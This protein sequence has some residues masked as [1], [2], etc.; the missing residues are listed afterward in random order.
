MTTIPGLY[1]I[2]WDDIKHAA[3]AVGFIG[4]PFYCIRNKCCNWLTTWRQ[5]VVRSQKKKKKTGK[6]LVKFVVL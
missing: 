6:S 1:P 5:Q 2:W 3:E 4:A